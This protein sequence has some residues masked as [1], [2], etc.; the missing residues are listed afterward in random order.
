MA[1][2]RRLP[3]KRRYGRRAR[4]L[5]AVGGQR[6]QAQSPPHEWIG[7]FVIGRRGARQGG[8]GHRFPRATPAGRF[9]RL[10]IGRAL[11]QQGQVFN[12]IKVVEHIQMS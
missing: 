1:V 6:C 10:L 12:I 9:N 7:V 11:A 4:Q 3:A 5:R 2:F 8:Q